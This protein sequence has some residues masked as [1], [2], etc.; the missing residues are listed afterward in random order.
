MKLSQ[1]DFNNLKI[2]IDTCS[3]GSIESI[4]V[5]DGLAR[6]VNDA[7]TMAIISDKNLPKFP[8]KIGLSRISGLKQKLALFSSMPDVVMNVSESE[9]G[10]ISNLEIV[11]GKN[12]ATYRCTSTVLIKAPKSINDTYQFAVSMTQDEFKFIQNGIKMMGA[13]LTSLIIRKNK[14]VTFTANDSANDSFTA[15]LNTYVESSEDDFDTTVFYYN[16]DILFSLLRSLS[17]EIIFSIGQGGSI[18]AELNGHS[19]YI[20]PSVGED[21]GD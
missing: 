14:E 16:T 17:G 13:K 20:M 18:C 12:K 19:L 5:E 1:A 3:I 9:R 8:Q 7:R 11:S 15:T 21:S 6:G 10:E 4:I 2:L